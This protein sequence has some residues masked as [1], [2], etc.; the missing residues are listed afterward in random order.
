MWELFC[1]FLVCSLKPLGSYFV[2]GDKVS[3]VPFCAIDPKVQRI[4]VEVFLFIIFSLLFLLTFVV[5]QGHCLSIIFA[6]LLSASRVVFSQ[7]SSLRI[8]HIK[9][10]RSF[11]L[12]PSWINCLSRFAV[13]PLY[14]LS[15]RHSLVA[16][17]RFSLVWSGLV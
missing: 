17:R 2:R 8:A 6:F 16:D 12:S 13:T 14:P 10:R 3:K 5:N 7:A 4:I 11:L 15:P 1:L 9:L